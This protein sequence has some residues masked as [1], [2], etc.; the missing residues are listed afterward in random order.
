MLKG[1]KCAHTK[2]RQR[3]EQRF[4]IYKRT[5]T[6]R[7]KALHG[8]P[9]TLYNIIIYRIRKALGASKNFHLTVCSIVCLLVKRKPC[10]RAVGCMGVCVSDTSTFVY[11]S[12]SFWMLSDTP[13]PVGRI[14]MVGVLCAQNAHQRRSESIKRSSWQS[15]ALSSVL[16]QRKRMNFIELN[17]NVKREPAEHIFPQ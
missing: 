2:R 1:L 17:K 4:C 9:D 12:T 5:H 15:C 7:N 11:F 13:I 16:R 6:F 14:N 10:V 3:R 8:P